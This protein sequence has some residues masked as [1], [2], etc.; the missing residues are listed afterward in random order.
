MHKL[1]C[2]SLM[3]ADWQNIEKEIK[4]LNEADIDIYHLDIMDGSF[5]PNMALGVEDVEAVRKLTT[6]TIDVHL[7]VQNPQNFIDLFADLGV[8]IIYIHPEADQIPSRTLQTIKERGIHPGLAINPGTSINSVH[9]LLPLV[10]YV[11]VMTVDPG[12]SGQPFLEYTIPKIKTLAEIKSNYHYQLMVDGAISENRIDELSSIGVEG[13]IVGSSAL[14]RKNDNYK[15]IVKR[16]KG[17]C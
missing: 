2:P 11:L 13:F 4:E 9:E 15:T 10:D 8:N 14:F 6:K 1:I 12:F 3:V 5:V 17:G 16:L 7:M